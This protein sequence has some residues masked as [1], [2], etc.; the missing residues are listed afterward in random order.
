MLTNILMHAFMPK[1]ENKSARDVHDKNGV[2]MWADGVRLAQAEGRG[3]LTYVWPKPGV[4]G[5]CTEVIV[6]GGIQAVGLDL[7]YGRLH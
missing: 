2:Y 5:R 6:R 1:M 7:A 4:P 3:F